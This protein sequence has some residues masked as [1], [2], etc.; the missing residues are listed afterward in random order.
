[1]KEI[2][3]G[4]DGKTPRALVNVLGNQNRLTELRRPVQHPTSNV[5]P[6]EC[7]EV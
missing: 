6:V 4:R 2:I 5:V 1:M 3:K 7:K